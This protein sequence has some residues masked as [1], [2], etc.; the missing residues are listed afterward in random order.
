MVGFEAHL[1]GSTAAKAFRYSA[2]IMA[3]SSTPQMSGQGL[4]RSRASLSAVDTFLALLY[5]MTLECDQTYAAAL[6]AVWKA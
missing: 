3:R 2:R 1:G 4:E 6:M 5:C